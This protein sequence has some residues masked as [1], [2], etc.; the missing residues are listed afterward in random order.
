MTLVRQTLGKRG[1]LAVLARLQRQGWPIIARN[2]RHGTYGEI[3]LV[4][5]DVEEIVFIEVR[6][7]RGPMAAAIDA[8]LESLTISKRERLLML[9]QAYLAEREMTD[10]TVWRVDIAA[11]AV[12]TSNDVKIELI[13]DALAW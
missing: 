8:A 6:T 5:M 7:R 1:E 9:A 4:A 13:R 12:V 2:W 3:D 11:V 10:N